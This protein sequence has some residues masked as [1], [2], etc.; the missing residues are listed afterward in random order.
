[1]MLGGANSAAEGDTNHHRGGESTVR[2]IPDPGDMIDHLVVSR[3]RESHEL[4][5][6]NW[7]HPRNGHPKRSTDDPGLGHWSVVYPLRPVFF[8]E[9]IGD[10]EHSSGPSDIFAQ[11]DYPIVGA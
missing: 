6:D 11:E 8:Q 9:A 1:M 10:P 2:A 7:S 3:V 4:H 5:F